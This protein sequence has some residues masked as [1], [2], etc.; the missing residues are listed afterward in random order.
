MPRQTTPP[1]TIGRIELFDI[2]LREI[3]PF[4]DWTFFFLAW[5][6]TGKFKG[7]ENICDCASCEATWLRQFTDDDKEKAVEA[8]R[9]F[10]D[11]Q[12][13][14]RRITAEKTVY[15]NAVVAIYPAHSKGEDIV[16]ESPERH[17]VLPM[18]RQQSPSSDGY[19]YS[20]ADFLSEKDDFIGAF[21]CT[22]IGVE[23]EA[24]VFDENDDTYHSLL[25][26]SLGDR[27]AEATAEWLHCRVRT[28]YWGY[29]TDELP[30][31]GKSPKAYFDGIRPAVGYP[32]LPDQSLIFALDELL[33]YKKT[34]IQLTENG[35]M[36][37]S[38]SVSG[39]YF[40]HPKAKYFIIGKIDDEQLNDYARRRGK[41]MEEMKKWLGANLLNEQTK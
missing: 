36:Y 17:I 35:A 37:P 11:G 38:A 20:L 2:D 9:L 31:N 13:M 27:L 24:K 34:G 3:A 32:S 5:R 10:R 28:D 40:A 23:E 41:T 14:L 6:I 25:I 1:K 19:C 33:N 39:L 12:A 29:S 18:L 22:V 7:I 26:K 8:L 4:I 21:A 15:I 30:T 16:I